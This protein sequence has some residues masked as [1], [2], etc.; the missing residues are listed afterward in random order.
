MIILMIIIMKILIMIISNDI[1][2]NNE[3]LII[4]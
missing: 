1:N 4:N 2:D 3:I